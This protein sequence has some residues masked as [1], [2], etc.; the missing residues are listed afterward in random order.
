MDK[1][2]FAEHAHGRRP[3]R[4][5]RRRPA[6]PG[7]RRGG[8]GR[9]GLPGRG[10]AGAQD[11]PAWQAATRAKAIRVE[12]RGGAAGDLRPSASAWADVLIAQEWVDGHRGGRSTPSNVYFDRASQPQVTFVA[13]KLRQWPLDDRDELSRRG[14]PQRRGP[15]R[16][17]TAVRERRLPRPRLRRDEARRA[18]RAA[19]HHRAEH[20]PADRALVDRR[21][22]R[23]RAAHD[24]LPRRPR[25]AAPG[26]DATSATAASSG[27][28]GA[29]T[30]RPRSS[31]CRR[32]ELSPGGWWRSVRGPKVEAVFSRRDPLP[33][34]ADVTTDRRGPA[35][36]HGA[37][38]G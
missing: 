33:F 38:A 21:A 27:S 22:R 24:R 32:G 9:A 35:P 13:R 30:C 20:R 19:L 12:H 31:G 8:R 16:S 5:R 23:G 10:Q 7:G 2:R 28:T 1:V 34:V 4:S 11:G 18:D 29:T 6:L 17:A 25:R 15:R 14:G 36:G 3:G 26:G 37:G